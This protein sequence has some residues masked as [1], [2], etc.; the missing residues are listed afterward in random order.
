MLKL[1]LNG[2]VEGLYL[3]LLVIISFAAVFVALKLGQKRLP[4]DQGRKFALNGELSEGKPRGAGIII[5]TAFVFCC[6]LFVPLNV[7]LILYLVLIYLSMVS[8]Y[9]DDSAKKSW[10]PLKKGLIDLVIS[11]GAA[12]VFYFYNGGETRLALFGV[13]FEIPA[14]LLY[15]QE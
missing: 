4:R 13:S 1:I 7:E 2:A 5:I 6:A 8:G 11:A 15:F 10:G 3:P 12:S 14:V 9:L